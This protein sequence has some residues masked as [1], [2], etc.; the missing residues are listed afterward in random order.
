MIKLYEIIDSIFQVLSFLSGKMV[1][2]HPDRQ[3]SERTK[4]RLHSTNILFSLR[5][6]VYTEKHN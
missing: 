3:T 4:W 5:E 1:C 2:I 6:R